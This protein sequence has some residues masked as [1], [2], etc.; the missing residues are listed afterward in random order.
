MSADVPPPEVADP[1]HRYA[2]LRRVIRPGSRG[3]EIG[4][5]RQPIAPK[6]EGYGTLVVDV[7]DAPALR[8]L[9]RQRGYDPQSIE[10]IEEVD[11]VGDASRL[12]GLVRGAGITGSFEWIVSCH[13]FEHL[14][15]PISFLRDCEA[16]LAPGGVLAMIVPDKRFCFDRFQPHAT[17]AG[18]VEAWDRGEAAMGGPEWAAFRQRA[19][20]GVRVDDHGGETL[21]WQRSMDDPG[22][23]RLRHPGLTLDA[24]RRRRERP[25][26][27]PFTGHRWRY[28][29]AVLAAIL[30]DLR[31]AGL[32]ALEA[33]HVTGTPAAEFV[34]VLRLG[35][36]DAPDA[37]EIVTRRTALYRAVED[38]AAVVS[39][40]YRTLA[41]ELAAARDELARLRGE[42]HPGRTAA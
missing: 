16:L 19:L 34:A 37:E 29:P 12:Q 36:T 13:N 21:L 9:A 7:M 39:G 17:F 25:P 2:A 3:I 33:E 10:R 11:L 15:D 42:G 31:V 20:F 22:R 26:A 30:F 38:E 14:P 41:A 40:A 5:W 23:M 24:L 35:G 8:A 6:S 32:T 1:H 28:T 4:P 18:V 27:A